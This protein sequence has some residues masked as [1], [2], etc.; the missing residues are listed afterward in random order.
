MIAYFCGIPMV[1][2]IALYTSLQMM[3]F[4]NHVNI[5]LQKLPL[6]GALHCLYLMKQ[7]KQ[8]CKF[9]VDTTCPC[10]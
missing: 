6:I 10:K 2:S 9:E 7:E 1:T 8:L 3:W 5:F 4:R